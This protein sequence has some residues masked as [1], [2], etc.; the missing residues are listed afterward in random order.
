MARTFERTHPWINFGL[1]TRRFSPA[2]WMALGEASS[3]CEHIAGVPLAPDAAEKMYRLYLVKGALATTAIEGNTLS[4][5]EAEGI[6]NGTLRLPASQQYLADE[7]HN[8]V[9]ATNTLTSRLEKHASDGT[10]TM[11]LLKEMNQMVLRD[12]EL[13]DDVVPGQIRKHSVVVGRYRCAPAEDCEYLLERF[14]EVLNSFP[15]PEADRN[16]YCII[17]AIFAHLYF[18]WIHPF[19]DGNGRTARLLELYILLAAGFPQPTGHL[20]SNHYNRTRPKYYERLDSAREG[21]GVMQ[22][23]EYSVVGL[24][25]GLR[26][27]ISYIRG[28]QWQVAWTNYVH[29]QFHNRNSVTDVRRRR[30]VIALSAHPDGVS[31]SRVGELSPELVREYVG[32]TAKTLARDVNALVEMGL[33]VRMKGARV[34]AN[35]EKI[36]AFLPWRNRDQHPATWPEAA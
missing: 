22:F 5:D 31:T 36:L 25:E 21:D 6:V 24:V 9:D 3:K 23:I 1:D 2:L 32:K 19:G 7:L 20:L 4:E 30:L 27:Q 16:Q 8:V 15:C 35:R 13:P 17:K 34:K 12:L 10:I 26:E 28:Q 33:I 11:D 29:E 18:V 14:C